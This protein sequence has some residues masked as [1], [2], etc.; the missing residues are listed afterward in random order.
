[1]P[2]YICKV[3]RA[4]HTQKECPRCQDEKEAEAR[5]V[6]SVDST[7]NPLDSHVFMAA[8]DSTSSFESSP[9]DSG[10]FDGGG[11]ESGGGGASGDW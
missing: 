3:C 8:V 10:G 7:S 9:S 11:G 4:R 5:R 1:M 2:A 6:S